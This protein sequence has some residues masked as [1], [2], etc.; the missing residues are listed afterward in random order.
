MIVVDTSGVLAAKDEDHPQH[1][2]V[3]RAL[4][5]TTEDLLLSPFVFAECDYMLA[6]TLGHKAAREFVDEVV[7]GAYQLVD[8]DAGDVAVAAG[9]MD[10]YKDLTIGMT[11]ASLVVIAARYQ[12]TR[13]LTFDH[14]HFRTVAPLWGATAFTLLPMDA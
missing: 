5:E 1:E 13:L 14:R 8:V 9:I 3:A 2:D 10:R 6:T 7:T 11:D 4:T 12:T